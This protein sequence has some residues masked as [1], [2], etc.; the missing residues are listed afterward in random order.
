MKLI[1]RIRSSISNRFEKI[2]FKPHVIERQVAGEKIKFLV[3]D[4]FGKNWYGPH[5]DLSP[6][7]E[8]IK[9]NCIRR[10]ALA[11]D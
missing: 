10:G 9:E 2:T 11:I 7:Y 5:H 1:N 3:G 8:W 4:L 6:E